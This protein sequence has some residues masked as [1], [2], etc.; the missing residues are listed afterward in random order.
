MTLRLVTPNLIERYRAVAI[1]TIPHYLTLLCEAGFKVRFDIDTSSGTA[2][3]GNGFDVDFTIGSE[4]LYFDFSVYA[5]D[6][7]SD[8][9]ASLIALSRHFDF[10][11]SSNKELTHVKR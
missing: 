9:I 6:F 1:S 4:K 5:E 8:A 2:Y 3:I 10:V 7:N 11:G